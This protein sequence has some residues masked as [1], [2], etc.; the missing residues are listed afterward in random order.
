MQAH[1]FTSNGVPQL[2]IDDGFFCPNGVAVDSAGNIYVNDPNNG[3]I[4]I[5][6]SAGVFLNT[7][8]GFFQPFGVAVDS[9]GNIYVNAPNN[10]GIQKFNSDRV[11]QLT[12]PFSGQGVT[13]DSTGNIYVPTYSSVDIYNSAGDLQLSIPANGARAVAVDSIG[14]IYVAEEFNQDIA[15]YNSAGVLQSIIGETGVSGSDNF[16]FAT[17]IG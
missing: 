16:H 9:T 17:P 5:Y 13:V 7:I 15:I 10:G 11:L 4:Q 14:N 3:R 8:G 6:D 2:T 1:T 12:F